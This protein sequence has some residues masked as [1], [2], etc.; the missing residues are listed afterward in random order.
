[1]N[2]CNVPLAIMLVSVLMLVAGWLDVN[3]HYVGA[4]E[5]Y[6]VL[7]I[8]AGA[9]FGSLFSIFQIWRDSNNQ[10]AD[11]TFKNVAA[12]PENLADASGGDKAITYPI[13]TEGECR[14]LAYFVMDKGDSARLN[15]DEQAFFIKVIREAKDKFEN[16]H[17]NEFWA[18]VYVCEKLKEFGSPALNVVAEFYADKLTNN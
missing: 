4:I 16:D 18:R 10:V 9:I 15:D 17:R 5:S 8:P 1:M 3:Q 7:A 13:P 12:A 2:K 14:L 6:G 11:D